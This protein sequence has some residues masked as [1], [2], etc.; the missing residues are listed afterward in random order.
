MLFEQRDRGQESLA[1]QAALVQIPGFHVRR[2]HERDATFEQSLEQVAEDHR[3]GD[4]GDE[5]LVEADD[6]RLLRNLVRHGIERRLLTLEPLEVRVHLVHEPVEVGAAF[7]RLGE[8]RVEQ[9]HEPGLAATDTA[10]EVHAF[11]RRRRARESAQQ[12]FAERRRGLLG[13]FHAQ[14]LEPGHR[15]EL[16][17]VGGKAAFGCLLG[18]EFAEDVGPRAHKSW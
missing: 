1:L 17:A 16:G 11:G 4:V 10:P 9:I 7:R 13:E 6:A 3:V 5:Q 15:G 14:P 2:E 12:P 8:A 18:V